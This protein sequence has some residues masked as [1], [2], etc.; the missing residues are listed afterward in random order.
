VLFRS[1]TANVKQTPEQ[2]KETSTPAKE[3][4]K[5][6]GFEIIC[7]VVSLLAVFCIKENNK[8]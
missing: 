8:R 1:I 4:K 6:P 3:N 5:T 7:G 2:K